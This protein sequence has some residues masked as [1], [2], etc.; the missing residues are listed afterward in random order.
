MTPASTHLQELKLDTEFIDG[1]YRHT[2]AEEPVRYETWTRTEIIG[3]GAFGTVYKETCAERRN[4]RAVKQLRKSLVRWNEIA[5]LAQLRSYPEHFVMLSGWFEDGINVYL[6][7]EYLPGD[8]DA[9][10]KEQDLSEDDTKRVT[11]QILAGL[12]ILHDNDI[13]HRD[14]K[15]GN[16]LIAHWIPLSVRIGDFGVSK[17]FDGNTEGRTTTGTRPFMA[18]EVWG[19]GDEDTSVYTTAVDMWSL[20]CLVYFMLTKELPFPE[21]RNLINFLSGRDPFPPS[22]AV[23]RSIPHSAVGFIASMLQPSPASRI[24]ASKAQL[25]SWLLIKKQHET[26]W[27]HILPDAGKQAARPK[28]KQIARSIKDLVLGDKN[29]PVPLDSLGPKTQPQVSAKKPAPVDC[30]P[31]PEK[32]PRASASVRRIGKRKHAFSISVFPIFMYEG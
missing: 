32:Q 17:H 29:E 28:P 25:H 2:I 24:P 19:F 1:R 14:L 9:L 30:P 18:P 8:L 7:M 16:I 31:G 23:T 26:I 5:I 20:G 15:P 6:A 12:E 21:T 13:C 11:K 22:T 3:E 4:L 27:N 10:L